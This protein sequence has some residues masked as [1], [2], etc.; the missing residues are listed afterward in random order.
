MIGRQSLVKFA[1]LLGGISPVE[2]YQYKF[3]FGRYFSK[4][5]YTRSQ[6]ER[7]YKNGVKYINK[8]ERKDR[9]GEVVY[10]YKYK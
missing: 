4:D 9:N 5:Y 3:D 2:N 8:I 10:S 7:N 6:N 1:N